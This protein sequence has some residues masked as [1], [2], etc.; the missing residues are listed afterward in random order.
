MTEN[1]SNLLKFIQNELTLLFEEEENSQEAK[2]EI[3]INDSINL[4]DKKISFITNQ[5]EFHHEKKNNSPS[6]KNK[7]IYGDKLID[8]YY[9]FEQIKTIFMKDEKFSHINQKFTNNYNIEAAEIKLCKKKRNRQ[10]EDSISMEDESKQQKKIKRGRERTTNNKFYEEHTRMSGDNI[11]KKIKVRLFVYLLQFLNNILNKKDED[12]NRLYKLNHKLIKRLN[13]DIDIKYVNM[14]LKD[15]FSMNITP[16]YKG[17]PCDYNKE[18]IERII[19][20]EER[21][22]DYNTIIF[23]FNMTF[24]EWLDMFTCKKDINYLKNKC[25]QCDG[26]NFEKIANKIACVNKLLEE[27][28]EKNDERYFSTFTFYLYNYERWFTIKSSRRP[29]RTKK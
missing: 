2:D 15:L 29:R 9:S 22:E 28:L 16:R 8:D 19:N 10:M 3:N 12:K 21:V 7:E 5:K 1:F 24:G 18:F 6:P 26:I 4:K 13:K 14:S 27:M 11:I 20:H 25:A 23:V 17:I